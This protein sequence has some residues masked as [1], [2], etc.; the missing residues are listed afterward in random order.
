MLQDEIRGDFGGFGMELGMINEILTVL[1][2]LK[3]T[4]AY[5][6]GIKSGDKIV[7]ID[8]ESTMGITVDK[9]VNKIRG[10]KG[11]KVTI[12]VS[13]EG[14][15][16]LLKFTFELSS[17]LNNGLKISD[18]FATTAQAHITDADGTLASATSRINAILLALENMGILNTV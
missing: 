9:A 1:S 14:E 7:E 5:R 16:E 6:A 2:A 8:G 18:N 17:I 12:T 13:R 4:P 3:D 11:T 15:E 10:E